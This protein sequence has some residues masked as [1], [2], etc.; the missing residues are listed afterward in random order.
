[1]DER[2]G[3]LEYNTW[4]IY[5]VA[6]PGINYPEAVR[7]VKEHEAGQEVSNDKKQGTP[8]KRAKVVGNK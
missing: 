3:P 5:G 8:A 4:C 1:M 2:R 7:L 6:H